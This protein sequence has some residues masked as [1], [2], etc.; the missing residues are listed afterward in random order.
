MKRLNQRTRLHVGDKITY[1][2]YNTPEGR[3]YG[4]QVKATVIAIHAKQEKP[5]EVRE[6]GGRTIRLHRKEI[7]SRE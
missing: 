7:R 6:V 1:R 5:I 3:Y 4:D 2:L